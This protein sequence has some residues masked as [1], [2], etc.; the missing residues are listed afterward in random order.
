MQRL[1]IAME[2][3]ARN[4]AWWSLSQLAPK[5]FAALEE[6]RE[7]ILLLPTSIPL[8][9]ECNLPELRDVEGRSR[10]Q[11]SAIL[12]LYPGRMKTSKD[13]R[14]A[15]TLARTGVWYSRVNNRRCDEETKSKK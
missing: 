10:P 12:F 3:I 6:P 14:S 4:V 2:F 7:V 5:E 8:A 1:K 15:H 9:R 11:S 13:D